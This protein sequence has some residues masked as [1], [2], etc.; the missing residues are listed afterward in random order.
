[1]DTTDRPPRRDTGTVASQISREV[2]RLHARLFGR[3]P[4]RAKTYLEEEYALCILEEVFTPAE[5]TLITA[6]RGDHVHGTRAAFQEALAGEFITIVE[7]ATGRKV[8]VFMSEVSIVA[9]MAAELF[10]LEPLRAAEAD[11][12][13]TTEADDG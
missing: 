8:R 1:M 6:G 9:D 11:V 10:L 4:T 12:A 13:K 3:G 2:V 7:I 5:K